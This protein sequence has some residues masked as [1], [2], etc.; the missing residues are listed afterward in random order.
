MTDEGVYDFVNAC[1]PSPPPEIDIN[2]ALDWFKK[3]CT[4]AEVDWYV[5]EKKRV[6]EL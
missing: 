2:F 4:D 5:K 3:L 1:K 6:I